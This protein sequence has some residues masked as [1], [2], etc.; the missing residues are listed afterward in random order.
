[1]QSN[2]YHPLFTLQHY[3]SGST[4]DCNTTSE[5]GSTSDTATETRTTTPQHQQSNSGNNGVTSL[6]FLQHPTFTSST[7]WSHSDINHCDN[8]DDSEEK[9]DDSDDSDDELPIFQCRSRLMNRQ[10][11]NQHDP[12]YDSKAIDYATTLS[13]SN[14]IPTRKGHIT[15][16]SHDT[17]NDDY[18]GTKQL[19]LA[20]SHVNGEAYIWDLNKRCVAFPLLDHPQKKERVGD[21][22][23]P[24]PGLAILC[25]NYNTTYN[26]NHLSSSS[27]LLYQTRDQ[28][29]TISFH[30]LSSSTSDGCRMYDT[31]QCHSKTFC[32][33]TAMTAATTTMGNPNIIATPSNHESIVSLWD[34]RVNASMRG[35]R[36]RPVGVIHGAGLFTIQDGKDNDFS[37]SSSSSSNDWRK[38]GMVM[39]LKFC[40][41]GYSSSNDHSRNGSSSNS[42]SSSTGRNGNFVL[43][44]GM[45][46]G[47]LYLHDLRKLNS[48]DGVVHCSKQEQEHKQHDNHIELDPVIIAMDHTSIHL[49]KNPIL[50]IDMCP[51][52]S[53]SSSSPNS[54]S[55]SNQR[56]LIAIAGTA[57]DA[58]EQLDL[59]EAERGTVN[60]IKA[61]SSHQ[62]SPLSPNLKTKKN[63]KTRIR[64]KV[65]TCNVSQDASFL[66]KPGV[67]I[68]RFQPDGSCFAVGGWD[69]RIRI[70]SRTSAKLLSVLKGPNEDS[71]TSLDWARVISEV[72]NVNSHSRTSATLR[73]SGRVL[74]ASGSSDGK[75]TLWR[76]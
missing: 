49:G 19:L 36:R 26:N 55:N 5:T 32:Q 37:H 25:L 21:A 59:P 67:G 50:T 1:M 75:I 47:N 66:G 9:E 33:A 34:V 29:G 70:Y 65:G 58:V 60:V 43:G 17:D 31:I 30:N 44:C 15:H 2:S 74:L 46:S 54:N 62:S 51:S 41:W 8:S 7:T 3:S 28:N 69:R 23:G 72:N 20:S 39:S 57:G 42:S 45:E 63:L 27:S 64:A 6:T 16:H 24:S 35:G 38:E 52:S 10:R 4:N 11:Q 40:D 14:P 53:S 76:S 68:C 71:I 56:S 61:S 48:R 73:D 18:G 12:H 22:N 13:F